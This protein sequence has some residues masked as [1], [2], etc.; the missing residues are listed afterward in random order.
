MKFFVNFLSF[1]A[2]NV[3]CEG[4]KNS[5]FEPFQIVFA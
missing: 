3:V 2:T 1:G 4:K 5:E